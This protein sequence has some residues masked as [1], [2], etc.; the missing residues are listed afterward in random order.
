MSPR[1]GN[2]GRIGLLVAIG[3]VALIIAGS[4]VLLAVNP[5]FQGEAKPTPSTS[6]SASAT[7]TPTASPTTSATP[8][9]TPSASATPEP[10]PTVTPTGDPVPDDAD[11]RAAVAPYLSD[12]ETGLSMIEVSV[13]GGSFAGT[14]DIVRPMMQD[15]QR[16][17]DHPKPS[18]PDTWKGAVESYS[19][20]L[21][22]L[23]QALGN[24]DSA[25]TATALES[26]HT[27]LAT[28]L[29]LAQ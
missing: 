27:S 1:A 17:L 6:A 20:A 21:D 2:S 10:E 29:D 5:P 8:T 3:V 14:Q 13:D 11:F 28:L 7:A 16:L 9:A 24:T 18:D 22:A 15:V 4:A 19:G 12:A 25:R 23:Y 26:A